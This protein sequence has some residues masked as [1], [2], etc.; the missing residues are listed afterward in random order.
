MHEFTTVKNIVERSIEVAE[1]EGAKEITAIEIEVGELTMLE[2]EQMEFWLNMML[3]STE[4]GK[5]SKIKIRQIKGVIKCRDCS[6]KGNLETAGLDHFFPILICPKCQSR[7]IEIVEGDDCII[8]S[9]EIE[10]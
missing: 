3:S 1:N 10:D 7:S 6:Y 9:L 5:S 8:K 2:P 4:L